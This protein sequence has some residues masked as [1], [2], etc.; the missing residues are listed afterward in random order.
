MKHARFV[1]LLILMLGMVT[2]VGAN[3]SRLTVFNEVLSTTSDVPSTFPVYLSRLGTYYAELYIEPGEAAAGR[4]QTLVDL[5]VTVSFQ[6]REK[7]LFARDVTVQFSPEKNVA[8]LFFIESPL[9]L[10]QRKGVD[11]VVIFHHRD[12]MSAA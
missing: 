7:I 6:R 4:L 3:S 1:P 2:T 9:H 11:M 10:P 8:I 5:D 12:G